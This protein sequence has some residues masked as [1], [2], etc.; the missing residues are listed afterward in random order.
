VGAHGPERRGAWRLLPLAV[1]GVLAAGSIAAFLIA[2]SVVDDQEDRLLAERSAEVKAL[3]ANSTTRIESTLAVVGRLGNAPDPAAGGLFTDAAGALVER[4][5]KTVGVVSRTADGFEGVAVVGDGPAAGEPMTGA[6]A[7]LV[8]RALQAKRMVTDLIVLGPETRLMFARPVE[9]SATVAYQESTINPSQPG[10]TSPTSAFRNVR[11]AL[12]ASPEVD[13]SRLL[14][15]TEASGSFGGRVNRVPFPVGA[16]QWLMLIGARGPLVGPETQK[17]PWV[18]L[19]GGLAVSVLAASMAE[20]LARRRS[21]AT[22][23]VAERTAELQHDLGELGDT[24]K[25]LEQLLIAGPV[26]V[27]R[28]TVPGRE[29]SYVSPNSERL[30]GVDPEEALVPG[31][32]EGLVHPEDRTGFELALGRVEQGVSAREQIEHRV[33]V[34][35]RPAQWV[36]TVLVPERD[37]D[38]ATVA[39]LGY[40]VDVDDRRRA[41]HAQGEAQRAA[42]AASRAKSEF[43]SRMSH[44]LRTPLNAVLGFA[45]LLELDP[46]APAQE[47]AV[48]HILKG[49]RHLLDLINEVLD[50]S[51]IEAGDLALSAEAVHTTEI[52]QEAVDLIRP[53]AEQH[54]IQLVIAGAGCDCYIFADRQ[55]VKQILLNL[56]SNAVKYNR[57]RGTIAV[58]CEQSSETWVDI[59]VADTGPGV[60]AERMGLL[61]TPFERLGAEHTGV[62]GTG[63]GLALSQRLAAA[64]G[65]TL[66]ATST[67]GKGSTF[68]VRLPK[69]EGPLE[70][71]ERLNLVVDQPEPVAAARERAILYIEDNL[72]NLKL[73]ERVL[74]QRGELKVIAAMQGRLGLELAREHQPVLVLLDLH[75]PDMEGEQVLQR[76]RDDP[77]TAAIPVVI[78][79]ADA[80]HGQVQRLLTAGAFAYLTK[81]IDVRE[82]LGLLD[83]TLVGR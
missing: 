26:L 1:L 64:M 79:S 20:I 21:Y 67:L 76:L 46:L 34:G 18:F 71:Y 47:D 28:V 14:L 53:L 33:M 6:R 45:Q 16:D 24:R 59:A 11:A 29:V 62:E 73:V 50:I 39:M 22:A 43:L 42:E 77:A 49:G 74:A 55:R 17:M 19:I 44:E 41:E 32:L 57:P 27:W 37:E 7:A 2:R 78:V 72:S 15:S 9:G 40:V 60:P 68:T 56:L 13:P 12:Y 23:L 61:F 66:E 52:V 48:A 25:F 82:L 4:N 30:F 31:Y 65:G 36:S 80:T 63:I 10:G 83:D 35:G 81:P 51:R 3:L 58:S 8:E 75:L 54:D 69:V 5:T 38:G 70:R